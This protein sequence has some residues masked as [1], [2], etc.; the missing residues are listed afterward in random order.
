MAK[1]ISLTPRQLAGLWELRYR[2]RL[3]LLIPDIGN[4]P[5]RAFVAAVLFKWIGLPPSEFWA[6]T[7][8]RL[9]P[10]VNLAIE[11]KSPKEKTDGTK[12]AT[13][14]PKKGE[15]R[16]TINARMIDE[17]HRNPGSMAWSSRKWA[18]H[19]DCV[20][21]SVEKTAAWKMILADRE[22]AKSSRKSRTPKRYE[23]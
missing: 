12:H 19:F 18:E 4:P 13:G 5:D 10:F 3:K 11:A 9:I 1:T 16:A 14:R 6:M 23:E 15:P 7:A 2:E 21:A 17:L 22:S 8:Q 20:K